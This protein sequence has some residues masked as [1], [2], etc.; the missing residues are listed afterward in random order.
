M[1]MAMS[2]PFRADHV[3]S[4]LRPKRLIARRYAHGSAADADSLRLLEDE[5]IREVVA[6]Q[7][8]LGLQVVTDGEFRRESWRSGFLGCVEGL[9]HRDAQ[10]AVNKR[11]FVDMGPFVMDAAPFTV[12]KIKRRSGIAIEEFRFLRSV[13]SRTPK[14]TLPAPSFM[15]FFAGENAIERSAYPH[16]D[17]FCADLTAIYIE[18]I[19]ELAELGAT[20]VQ[21]DDAPLGFLCDVGVRSRMCRSDIDVNDWA[22]LYVE[23]LNAVVSAAPPSVT[24]AIHICRGNSMG[25]S[26]GAGSFEP[27]AARLFPKLKGRLLFL[28]FDE[29][30]HGD[31]LRFGTFPTTRRW[32][33]ASSARRPPHSRMPTASKRAFARRRGICRWNGCA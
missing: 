17:A 8:G 21:L 31:L 32:C 33:S 23:M 10:A 11:G 12:G 26:G 15:H 20:Y 29:P 22:D 25:I 30:D 3:G 6:F 2:Q 13:A 5:C 28:E 27:V 4:L 7:E 16:L 19:A 14:I 9:D 1:S 18:E 24:V